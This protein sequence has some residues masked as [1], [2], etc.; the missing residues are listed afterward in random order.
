MGE[1]PGHEGGASN[2]E[3]CLGYCGQR[4]GSA[5]APAQ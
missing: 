4:V 3:L 1:E 5:A 2:G